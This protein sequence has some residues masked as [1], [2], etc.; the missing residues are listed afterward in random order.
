MSVSIS[1]TKCDRPVTLATYT[2]R[3]RHIYG[4]SRLGMDTRSIQLVAANFSPLADAQLHTTNADDRVYEFTNHLG[5][6]LA[7]FTGRKLPLTEAGAVVGFAT[8]VTSLTDYYP[9]D[10]A[11]KGRTVTEGYRYGFNAMEREDELYAPGSAYDFGARVYDGRLGRWWSVDLFVKEACSESPFSF[12]RNGPLK[13][14]DPNGERW[15]NYYDAQ[16]EA[17]QNEVLKNPNS[18]SLQRQLNRLQRK[19]AEVDEIIS[20]LKANDEALYSYIEDL[21]VFDPTTCAEILV[22][23][24]VRLGS[25]GDSDRGTSPSKA[26]AAQTKWKKRTP[27]GGSPPVVYYPSLDGTEFTRAPLTDKGN[28]GFDVKLF[29]TSPGSADAFLANEI[30]D[31]MFRMEYPISSSEEGT[32]STM[33]DGEYRTSKAGNYSDSIEELYKQ[34]RQNASS[35]ANNPYPLEKNE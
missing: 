8:H 32:Q 24:V 13:Y 9:F 34:R 21:K 23:V 35:K 30:G 12:S 1:N 18:K 31:V 29:D 33:T 7:T 19:K 10:S 28:I 27:E 4:S 17:K 3:E 2:Q 11:M 16:I 15:V 6:V 20:T 26:P 14:L 22:D 25:S 5:N